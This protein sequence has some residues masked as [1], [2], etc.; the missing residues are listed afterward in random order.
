LGN[1]VPLVN[2]VTGLGYIFTS[3]NWRTQ[4]LRQGM[5]RFL[6][7]L[8]NRTSSFV[9]VQNP[10]DRAALLGVGVKQVRMTLIPGS[11]IDTDTLQPL[12]ERQGTITFGF[13]GRLLADK[14]ARALVAAHQIL[15]DRGYSY[16]LLIAGNPDPVN[17]AS[18]ALSEV[19]QWAQTP[20]FT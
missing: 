6:P 7:L 3:V 17:P 13:A 16:T 4:L 9:L 12:P 19:Q 1:D 14:G 10:D 18:I 20:G 2:A 15:R 5:V 11:G 8:L